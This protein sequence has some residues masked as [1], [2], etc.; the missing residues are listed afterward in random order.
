MASAA[1]P[2][3]AATSSTRKRRRVDTLDP[4]PAVRHKS[5]R[6]A[7]PGVA[8]QQIPSVSR[9]LR[10]YPSRGYHYYLAALHTVMYG[11]PGA[12][13][14]RRRDVLAF[15]GFAEPADAARK[16]AALGKQKAKWNVRFLKL[17]LSL[18]GLSL[19]GTR[20]E[21]IARLVGF[22]AKPDPARVDPAVP[23]FQ[24]V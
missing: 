17:F 18:M 24:L 1:A 10:L 12:D 21:L 3:A 6:R 2:P 9:K 11:T 15:D 4:S 7:G 22:L 20:E 14:T 5:P 19:E 16:A 13:A 23:V 8:L